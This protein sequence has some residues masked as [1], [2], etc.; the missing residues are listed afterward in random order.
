MVRTADP[1][2]EIARRR[3][4]IDPDRGNRQI[5]N[6]QVAGLDI[7][8]QRCGWFQRPQQSWFSRRRSG[9]RSGPWRRARSRNR[10]SAEMIFIG[11]SLLEL[12]EQQR[13]RFGF[14]CRQRL[15]SAGSEGSDGLEQIRQAP[16]GAGVETRS[17]PRL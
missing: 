7:N 12:G 1:T 10:S 8:E 5:E 16:S 4:I 11:G 13:R 17:S 6:S 2:R 3:P 15:E 9:R 14:L